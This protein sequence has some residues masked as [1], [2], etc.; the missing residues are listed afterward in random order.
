MNHPCLERRPE[1]R[2]VLPLR[3]AWEEGDRLAKPTLALGQ[4][5]VLRKGI[6]LLLLFNIKSLFRIK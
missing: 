3:K 4:I 5:V 6:L 2:D 1:S